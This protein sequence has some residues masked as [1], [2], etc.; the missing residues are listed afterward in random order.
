MDIRHTWG[1]VCKM[2]EQCESIFILGKLSED[3]PD[4]EGMGGNLFD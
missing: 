1:R 2:H 3:E 4:R